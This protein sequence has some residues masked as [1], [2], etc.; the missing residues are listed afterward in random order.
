MFYKPCSLDKIVALV[1]NECANH[2]TSDCRTT[3]ITNKYIYEG[4]MYLDTYYA[5]VV[6]T[7]TVQLPKTDQMFEERNASLYT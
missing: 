5:I 2:G 4:S 1:R 3:S 6:G 7:S